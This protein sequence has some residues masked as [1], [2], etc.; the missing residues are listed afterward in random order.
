MVESVVTHNHYHNSLP[1]E[2]VLSD[3]VLS[4]LSN[5]I[6]TATS[7]T[8]ISFLRKQTKARCADSGVRYRTR[9]ANNKKK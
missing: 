2:L 3:F 1:L 9:P 5:F 8:I 4:D 7:C 6:I